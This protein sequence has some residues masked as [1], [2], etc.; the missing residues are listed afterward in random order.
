[1]E[2]SI[3]HKIRT[4]AY[5][6]N[7]ETV[8]VRRVVFVLCI[9]VFLV[10]LS[11]VLTPGGATDS[12]QVLSSD[13]SRIERVVGPGKVRLAF[14]RDGRWLEFMPSWNGDQPLFHEG[15]LLVFAKDSEGRLSTIVNTTESGIRVSEHAS[16]IRYCTE[17]VKGGF[18]A[19]SPEPDD[20]RDGRVNEDRLDGIDNDSDGKI[21]EDFAA[22]GDEMITTCYFAPGIGG[23]GAQLAFYQEAYA[24]SLPHIDGTIMVNLWI[25][26]I[27]SESLDDVRIGAFVEK[28]GPFYFSNWVVSL[29]GEPGQPHANVIVCEE[30]RG[31]SMGVVVFPQRN[32][33]GGSWMGGVLEKTEKTSRTLLDR[34]A[35]APGGGLLGTRAAPFADSS[36]DAY[37]FK[38]KET[39]IDGKTLV[40]QASPSFGS[41]PPGEEIPVNLAFFAV[42]ERADVEAA[43]INA[44]KTFAGD[45]VN[46]YLPPP[47]SMTPRV[48]WGSYVPI[49]SDDTGAKRVAIEFETLGDLP[50]TTDE[51][52]YFSGVD[53]DA[54][55]R[56]V[57]APG[58]ERVVLRGDQVRR[59]VQKGERIILKGR[60]ENG[61]FFEAILKPQEGADG[62]AGVEDDAELFWRTE[63][64]LE[65]ELLSSSPNPFRDATTIYYEIPSLIERPDGTRI[66][67][68]ESLK[69]SVKVYNVVG[70]LVEV[71]VEDVLSPGTY[72]TQWRA[73]DDQGNEVASGVYYVR[74]QIGKKYLTQR[75]ILLK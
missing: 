53:P 48:I 2:R 25:K 59:A 70:R 8:S 22:I 13:E 47:V 67:S 71:L 30:L 55:E 23:S 32:I 54:V 52:S 21:D 68:K 58:V 10:V 49:D 17:G 36:P 44:F 11:G 28:D 37:V 66:E 1:M 56:V 73:A 5:R 72:S 26:N 74:L 62:M 33:D 46:R 75:L 9:F 51:V 31:T 18:R 45:G 15:G 29:P 34:L 6:S 27:G 61:E 64:R 16:K 4:V 65:L 69:V 57:V 24:W 60:L 43:A 63:G 39:R 19:P 40:Y 42:R 3:A 35:N 7:G 41:L 50:V 12:G 14:T 38:T 20:D